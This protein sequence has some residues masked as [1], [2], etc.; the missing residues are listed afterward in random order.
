VEAVTT[1]T[2]KGPGKGNAMGPD[3]WR[4]LPRLFR[5]LDRDAGTRAIVVR[6]HGE[7]FSYGL[8]LLAMAPVLAPLL[9]GEHPARSRT[10]LLD[11]IAELQDATNAVARCRKPVIAAIDGYCIG[12][13][14][15]LVAAA[16]I[17]LASTRAIFSVRE[18][19]VA[20]VAD[21]GTLQ[22]L[23]GIIGEGH[24]R[25]LAFTGRDIDAARALAI[26]LVNDVYETADALYA[27]AHELATRIAENP[28]LVVEGI[29]RVRNQETETRA[30]VGLDHVA[31]WNAA[32]LPSDDLNEA[33]AA[34]ATRRKPVFRGS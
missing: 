4:E 21:L 31:L 26:G 34:F 7:H 16:D 33:F 20:M 13:G 10:E 15:D 2:L 30:Q 29:K 19:R 5:A 32:F 25:D 11:L 18:A 14:V 22:R 3:F 23:P 9:G 24:T 6:G 28:P 17:R 1:V 12:G 8:D 27:A